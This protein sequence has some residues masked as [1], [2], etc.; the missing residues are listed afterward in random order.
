MENISPNSPVASVIS[1]ARRNIPNATINIATI[2]SRMRLPAGF[3]LGFLPDEADPDAA[4]LLLPEAPAE[5]FLAE[6]V[7][8]VLFFAPDELLFPLPREAADLFLL[9]FSFLPAIFLP[10]CI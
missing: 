7:E 6:P 4:D 3:F 9:L 10:S 5:F 8:S 1:E 2:S